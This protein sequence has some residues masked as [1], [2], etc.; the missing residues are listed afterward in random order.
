[1]RWTLSWRI[2]AILKLLHSWG[3]VLALKLSCMLQSVYRHVI[4]IVYALR[5][6]LIGMLY[7]CYVH[8]M[9]IVAGWY[10]SIRTCAHVTVHEQ[11]S[12]NCGWNRMDRALHLLQL[13]CNAVLANADLFQSRF[14]HLAHLIADCYVG[15]FWFSH[16]FSVLS[17]AGHTSLGLRSEVTL[18][19]KAISYWFPSICVLQSPYGRTE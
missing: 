15:S 16:T 8:V 3:I 14:L 11:W 13:A 6:L 18:L 5:W 9:W 10:S 19:R 7:T 2:R 1:M 17:V 4:C 12:M